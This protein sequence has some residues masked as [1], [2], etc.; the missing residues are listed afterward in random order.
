MTRKLLLLILLAP[1]ALASEMLVVPAA[2]EKGFHYPYILRVP[3]ETKARWLLVEP[4]NTGAVSDDFAVHEKAAMDLSKKAIGAYVASRLGLPLLVPVFPRPATEWQIY[5]H[6][7]D[8]DSMLVRSGPMRRM[9]LQL[10]AMIDDARATLNAR[11]VRV[12]KKVL[13]T[14]FSASGTFSN[15]FTMMH[16]ERVHAV[17]AGGL[18]GLLMIPDELPYPLGLSDFR[19]VTGE[20][21]HKR[22]WRRVPQFLYMGATDD[23]DA[24]QFDDGYSDDERK[25]VFTILGE[26]MQPDR[27][28]RCQE[29]YRKAGANATFRTYPHIGH[30]TD[31]KINDEITEF[32]RRAIAE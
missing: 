23:N 14:G 15:R 17:A 3:E 4:N 26:K 13:M 30:G 5:T 21:F 29:L 20:R 25:L 31:Q 2:P 27:W 19:A 18:N 12:E 28:R 7:L 10:L 1:A 8:R 24:V 11:G 32:F 16:P 22:A 9:D 6:H